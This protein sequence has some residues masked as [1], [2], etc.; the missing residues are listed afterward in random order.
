MCFFLVLAFL[1]LTLCL[2]NFR[3]KKNNLDGAAPPKNGTEIPY[4]T[5]T[6]L[7]P[8]IWRYWYC[9]PFGGC[10]GHF[11]PTIFPVAGGVANREG[12][13]IVYLPLPYVLYTVR[14][15]FIVTY[16]CHTYFCHTYFFLRTYHRRRNSFQV[17]G[18]KTF[19][20][21]TVIFPDGRHIT[22]FPAAQLKEIDCLRCF[23]VIN[24][25]IAV[26]HPVFRNVNNFSKPTMGL[27]GIRITQFLTGMSG[28]SWRK[29]EKT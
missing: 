27:S 10:F 29:C 22:T 16:F 13:L 24:F 8:C 19:G 2:L 1:S 9:H 6:W 21:R 11:C 14:T 26:F 18:G 28:L 23:V 4:R 15:Y 25:H 12:S 20:T 17:G 5:T 3:R 7:R